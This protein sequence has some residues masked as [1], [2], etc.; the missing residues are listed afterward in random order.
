[1]PSC[2]S[3]FVLDLVRSS[4]ESE[5]RKLISARP[6]VFERSRDAPASTELSRRGKKV[7][8]IDKNGFHPVFFI[9]ILSCVHCALCMRAVLC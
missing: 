7:S 6:V 2:V 9:R 5:I 1:M 8:K 4:A 3:L